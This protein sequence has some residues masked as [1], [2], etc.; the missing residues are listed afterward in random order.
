MFF[1]YN[2]PPSANF[3]NF[4]EN[5]VAQSVRI[6]LYKD[7]TQIVLLFSKCLVF[8]YK[9]S[10]NYWNVLN[11]NGGWKTFRT[12]FITL[13]TFLKY[14]QLIE[15]WCSAT[16]KSKINAYAAICR[17]VDCA[18]EC[19]AVNFERYFQSGLILN[20]VLKCF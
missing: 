5:C 7:R 6:F 1:Q 12:S 18:T 11:Q 16:K 2:P 17:L 15:W 19:Y 13:W 10:R 3:K 4:D 20:R 8:V 9:T 14:V